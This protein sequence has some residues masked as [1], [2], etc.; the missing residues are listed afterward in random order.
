MTVAS[1]FQNRDALFGILQPI[2][3][4]WKMRDLVVELDKANVPC[5]SVNNYQQVFA[6]PQAV[7]RGIEVRAEH[8]LSDRLR[9]IASPM[10]L[11]K[12]PAQYERPP[13]LGEHTE[14]VL[15]SLL[16]LDAT[17]FEELK[18]KGVI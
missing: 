13:L 2:L 6:D 1:R 4:E 16:N 7:A 14:E 10:K 3:L 5:S 17:Q 15:K 18:Q 8:P 12:T 9:L 11:S